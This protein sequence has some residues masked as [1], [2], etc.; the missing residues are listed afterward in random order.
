MAWKRD[1]F[2]L[3]NRAENELLQKYQSPQLPLIDA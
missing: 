1:K 2:I 3:V